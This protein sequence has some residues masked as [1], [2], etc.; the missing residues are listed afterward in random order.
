[1]ICNDNNYCLSVQIFY[2]TSYRHSNYLRANHESRNCVLGK[3]F[4]SYLR[5]DLNSLIGLA[6]QVMALWAIKLTNKYC[7][8]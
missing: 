2:A 8:Q 3:G 7:L 6:T 5:Y 4:S 1:M